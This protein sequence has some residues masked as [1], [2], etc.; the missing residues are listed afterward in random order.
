[1]AVFVTMLVLLLISLKPTVI[2]GVPLP[3]IDVLLISNILLHTQTRIHNYIGGYE[4]CVKIQRMNLGT[5][6]QDAMNICLS[7][8]KGI[9]QFNIITYMCLFCIWIYHVGLNVS[10][11]FLFHII[12][13]IVLIFNEVYIYKETTKIH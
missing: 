5:T 12:T 3:L 1:M 8:L 4:E 10:F 11:V 9:I 6:L 2:Q 7:S 13:F